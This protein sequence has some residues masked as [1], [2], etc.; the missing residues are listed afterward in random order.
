MGSAPDLD[1]PSGLPARMA[2][3]GR[4]DPRLARLSLN[5]WTTRRLG[6][7]EVVDLCVHRGV[8]SVGLWREQVEEV[9]TERATR[10]VA[11]AG[12]HVSSLC[13]TGFFTS[14]DPAVRRRSLDDARLAIDQAAALGTGVLIVVAGGLPEGSRDLGAARARVTEALEVL[15]PEAGAAGIRLALEPLH[16]MY[17]ADR[18]VIS[19]L[20]QALDIVERFPSETVGVAV[21]SFH[22][23]WDPD[24]W[25]AI[26]RASDRIAALQLAD[27]ITPLP[28]D[29][30]LARGMLGD[31]HID[32]G[33]LVGAVEAVGYSGAIEVEIFNREVWE[34]D[35]G[36]VVDTVKRRFVELVAPVLH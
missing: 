35:P 18:S 23:W 4:D 19:T 21:D 16:P 25:D 1:V 5:Q 34:A 2:T 22:V 24:V 7:K 29:P 12:V 10:I 8:P 9:G 33:R 28:E 27:W 36:A 30:L 17:C 31:G 26:M 20:R 32:L 15:A 3:P 13:R 6:V 14:D 11:A